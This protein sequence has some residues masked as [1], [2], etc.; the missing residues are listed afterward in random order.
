MSVVVITPNT[1]DLKGKVV[2]IFADFTSGGA[3]QVDDITLPTYAPKI[4]LTIENPVLNVVLIDTADVANSINSS[5][6]TQTKRAEDGDT[7][8]EWDVSDYE[9]ISLYHDADESGHVM[10]T[11]IAAGAQQT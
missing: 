5:L 11:Y 3:S 2:S 1:P 4:D 10:V 8:G 9:T 6:S 7:D